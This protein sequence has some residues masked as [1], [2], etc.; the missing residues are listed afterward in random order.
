MPMRILAMDGGPS[1]VTWCRCL[2]TLEKE[3]PGFLSKIDMVAGVSAGSLASIYLADKITPLAPGEPAQEAADGFVSYMHE[4]LEY[5]APEGLQNYA[6]AL[7]GDEAMVQN[8]PLIE[9]LKKHITPFS[10]TPLHH[11]DRDSACKVTILAGRKDEPWGPELNRNWGPNPEPINDLIN[12][13]IRSSAY[14]MWLPA[15]EGRVDGA[16]YCNSPAS[17]VVTTLVEE[18][19]RDVLDDIVILSLGGDAGTSNLSNLVVPGDPLPPKPPLPDI[20]LPPGFKP[21][22]PIPESLEEAGEMLTQFQEDLKN[23]LEGEWKWDF[24]NPPQPGNENWGWKHWLAYPGNLCFFVQIYMNNIG[25]G[26]TMQA[27]QLLGEDKVCRLAPV[28]LMS[29][30]EAILGICFTQLEILIKLSDF[31]AAL[32]ADPVTSTLFNFQPSIQST[33]AWLDTHWMND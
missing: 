3:R 31:A 11:P 21:P 22:F 30:G 14:P 24:S 10:S 1:V 6:T 15:R 23:A 19:G 16:V 12:M 7:K 33:L 17:T 25:L 5:Y 9:F 26:S 28:G 18:H 27:R 4:L 13:A 32:W 20:K 2:Q 8:E 29:M